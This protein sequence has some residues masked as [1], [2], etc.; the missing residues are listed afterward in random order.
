MSLKLSIMELQPPKLQFGGALS[1]SD[2]K[3]GLAQAGP[4][5][6]QFGLARK[7]QIGVGIVGPQEM[8]DLATW[9]PD[10][11]CET[12]SHY[13]WLPNLHL[14]LLDFQKIYTLILSGNFYISFRY[15][16]YDQI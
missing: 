7:A 2:P 5:D 8:I 12:L 4:F 9:S 6:L 13:F 15:S 14:Q 10:V 1:V 11:D 3:V 16:K